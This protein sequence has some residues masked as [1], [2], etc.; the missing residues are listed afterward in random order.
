MQNNR[1][2]F[3]N[4]FCKY[5]LTLFVLIIVNAIFN[6]SQLF[7]QTVTNEVEIIE[8]HDGSLVNCF[9]TDGKL[10]KPI[11]PLK[12]KQA[13]KRILISKRAPFTD[14]SCSINNNFT[15]QQSIAT[16]QAPILNQVYSINSYAQALIK[17]NSLFYLF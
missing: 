10:P 1:K 8:T 15:Y 14:S 7:A 2:K 4:H 11:Q 3:V 17:H 9:I 16:F 5:I 6:T 12:K 13:Y